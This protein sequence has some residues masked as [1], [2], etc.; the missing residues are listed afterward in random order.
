LHAL[1]EFR[2][3]FWKRAACCALACLLATTPAH[4]IALTDQQAAEYEASDEPSRAKL[5][6]YLA[7][8]GKHDLAEAVMARYP[9][10]GR[11]AANRKLLI[12]GLIMRARGD[13]TGAA[14]KFRDA[15]ADDPS[16][17]LVRA[18]LA[19]TLAALQQDDSAKHHLDILA[20]SAPNEDAAKGVRAFIDQID[21]RQPLKFSAFL[22]AAPTTN[23]N[24]GS[25]HSTMKVYDPFT[26]QYRDATIT[27]KESGIGVSVGGSVGYSKR[28]GNDFFLV[29]AGNAYAALYEDPDAN[30]YGLSESLELRYMFERG[31]LGL[32]LVSSQS[33]S[34]YEPT[35]GDQD[36]QQAITYGPRVSLQYNFTHSDRLNAS[37]SYEWKDDFDIDVYDGA[38]ITAN[39]S[40]EHTFDPSLSV[41]L[42]GGFS[43]VETE[44]AYSSFQAAH[45][46]VGFYK[47][48]PLGITVDAKGR[49]QKSEFDAKF[50]T[51]AGPREDTRY[52]GNVGLTKRDLNLFGFAPAIDYTY[53]RNDSNVILYDY[54]SHTVDF[55]LTKDF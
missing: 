1:N 8:T 39:A 42:F 54:D 26:G 34:T 36:F 55:R 35:P 19:T 16:L 41:T 15:L 7:S 2:L 44:I 24:S 38:T 23:I 30:S 12:E 29:A 20:R 31:Y 45:V 13:L 11:F 10:Q 14:Q 48:L 47:E 22:S 51:I 18:E 49:V 28:V 4:A 21:A 3:T 9:L 37:A 25:N 32:G 5:L 50:P 33:L 46:G 17:T 6:I 52:V 53:V 27:T 40:I 43:D